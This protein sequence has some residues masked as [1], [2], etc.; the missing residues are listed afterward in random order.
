MRPASLAL[1]ERV[2]MDPGYRVGAAVPTRRTDLSEGLDERAR[3]Y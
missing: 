1:S 3:R 2:G